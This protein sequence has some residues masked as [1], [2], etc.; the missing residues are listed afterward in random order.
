MA[1]QWVMLQEGKKSQQL[2]K[3]ELL[4][5]WTAKE[6]RAAFP[7]R[8]KDEFIQVSFHGKSAYIETVKKIK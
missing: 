2:K 6:I 4:L 5:E 1:K 3:V 8:P 7:D